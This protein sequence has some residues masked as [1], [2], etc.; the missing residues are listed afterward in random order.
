MLLYFYMT[1]HIEECSPSYPRLGPSRMVHPWEQVAHSH[2]EMAEAWAYFYEA[3]QDAALRKQNTLPENSGI[4]LQMGISFETLNAPL[5]QGRIINK[6]T[7]NILCI[8]DH[9]MIM[10]TIAVLD[11]GFRRTFA[12]MF[13]AGSHPSEEQ[14]GPEDIHLQ[15]SSNTVEFLRYEADHYFSRL[16]GWYAIHRALSGDAGTQ[17]KV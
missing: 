6:P 4:A 10:N 16:R 9:R 12:D 5:L 1:E 17:A 3:L 13:C 2:N 11:A 14:N 8:V 15:L 7:G